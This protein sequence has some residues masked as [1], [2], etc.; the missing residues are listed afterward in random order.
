MIFIIVDFAMFYWAI[1][2]KRV[3]TPALHKMNSKDYVTVPENN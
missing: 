2:G 1:Q 3:E